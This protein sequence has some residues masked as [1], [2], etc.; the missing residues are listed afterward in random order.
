MEIL[1][2][3]DSD[4]VSKKVGNIIINQID[5]KPDINLGLATGRT[6]IPIYKELLILYKNKKIDY[7]KVK[8]FNIDEY[9]NLLIRD[10]NS[11]HYYMDKLFF[12]HINIKPENIHFP[13]AINPSSY[14]KLIK[15]FGGI[16]IMILGIG[17]NGHIAFNEP[18]SSIKSK[19]RIVKLADSTRKPNSQFFKEGRVPQKAVSVGISTIL[20]SKLIILIATGKGKAE[21]IAKTIK[22]KPSS[23]IP[24]SFLKRHKNVLFILDKNAAG[25]L[26]F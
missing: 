10:K 15:K 3:E 21:T 2:F 11:Y 8:T 17:K 13:S 4:L 22:S 25:K 1:I 24:A 5:K 20:K 9:F 14:D 6:M 19:T 7:S 18:G 23:K 12:K 16:D 26:N